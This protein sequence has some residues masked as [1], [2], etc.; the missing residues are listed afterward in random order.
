[1]SE[2][3]HRAMNRKGRFKTRK[4]SPKGRTV[5]NRQNAEHLHK[6]FEG[7]AFEDITQVRVLSLSLS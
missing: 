1:M 2:W 5:R 6:K 3:I 4:Q 7:V